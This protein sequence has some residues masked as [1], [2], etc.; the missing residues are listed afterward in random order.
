L[1]HFAVIFVSKRE[2]SRL[3]GRSGSYPIYGHTVIK[4]NDWRCQERQPVWIFV[5]V[6]QKKVLL[7]EGTREI[8]KIVINIVLCIS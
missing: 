7:R 4:K 3:F 2:Q 6:F 8:K 5:P 1:H